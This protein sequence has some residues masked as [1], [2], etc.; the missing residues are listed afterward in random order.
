VDGLVS[1]AVVVGTVIVCSRK[2][3]VVL[4]RLLVSYSRLVLEDTD[5]LI[6]REP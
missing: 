4:D 5:D 2:C 6:V 3:M 1:F